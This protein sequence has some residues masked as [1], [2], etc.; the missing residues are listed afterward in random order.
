MNIDN[1]FLSILS[2][3]KYILPYIE[4]VRKRMYGKYN[5]IHETN[6]YRLVNITPTVF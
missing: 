1:R 3:V 5:K 6:T 2:I 4:K